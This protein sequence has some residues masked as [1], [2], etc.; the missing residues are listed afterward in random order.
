MIINYNIQHTCSGVVQK[1]TSNIYVFVTVKL[2]MSISKRRIQWTFVIANMTSKKFLATSNNFYI[3]IILSHDNFYNI[4]WY[5]EYCFLR[6]PRYIDW[7][8]KKRVL[9]SNLV[10][11]QC[12]QFPNLNVVYFE[13]SSRSNL[14]NIRFQPSNL[15]S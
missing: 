11:K 5:I 7:K 2:H 9:L 3:P 13:H 10:I 4:P 15:N 12:F 1:A 8:H 6:I 14:S